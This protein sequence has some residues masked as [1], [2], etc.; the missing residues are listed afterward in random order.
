MLCEEAGKDLRFSLKMMF[1]PVL[2][3]RYSLSWL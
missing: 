1:A 2:E 3:I